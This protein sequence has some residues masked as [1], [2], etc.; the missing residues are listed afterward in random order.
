[1]ATAGIVMGWIQI[2]LT[3]VGLCCFVVYFIAMMGMVALNQ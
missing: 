3:V 1:M 2:G